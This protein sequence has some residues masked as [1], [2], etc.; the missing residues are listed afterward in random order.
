[1]EKQFHCCNESFR[2]LGLRTAREA[3]KYGAAGS[4]IG[5]V[6]TAAFARKYSRSPHDGEDNG[7][8]YSDEEPEEQDAEIENQYYNS[9]G[10][11]ETDP[12]GA[13]AGFAEVVRME[14]EKSEWGFKALKQTVKL[15]YKLGNY[16]GMMDAYS[17]MLTYI[18]SAV[19][20]N[21]S[22]KC[23]NNIMDFVS[24]SATENFGLLQEFY[25]TTLKALEEPKNE[26]LWFKTN[27][28]LCKIWFHMR[29]YGRMSKILEELHKS[30]QKEG[31]RDDQK[32]GTQLLEVYAI[33]IQLYMET[34][35]NKK[36][37][38][39]YKKALS[40]KSAIPHPNMRGIIHECGG[41]MHMAEGH[42]AEAATDFFEAFK[43]YD[44][45]RNQRHIQCLKY[46]VLVN[47]LMESK[48]TPLDSQEAKPYKNDPE[49][50]AMTNL[51]AAYQQN[52]ALEFERILKTNRS[53]IMDDPFI[54]NYI[55]DLLKNVRSE[56][57]LK[58]KMVSNVTP[59][60]TM[61]GPSLQESLLDE[62][63]THHI[64][65]LL[66]IY[67]NQDTTP[68]YISV[69]EYFEAF[70]RLTLRELP[71]FDDWMHINA[72][73]VD[74]ESP[75]RRLK[76]PLSRITYPRAPKGWMVV[77]TDAG[78][79]KEGGRVIS[80]GAFVF[81]DE[82]GSIRHYDTVVLS[83][84]SSVKE[85]EFETIKFAMY[86]GVR[87][88]IRKLSVCT[89]NFQ[90]L[91]TIQGGNPYTEDEF[92]KYRSCASS[93][94]VRFSCPEGFVETWEDLGIA[95]QEREDAY[96]TVQ[97][98]KSDWL[99]DGSE[100]VWASVLIAASVYN[101]W[102]N[103]F[104][105][106]TSAALL[107][108]QREI[109]EQDT[110]YFHVAHISDP[111][112]SAISLH[113]I[114]YHSW[115]KLTLFLQGEHNFN[116]YG[117]WLGKNS[118]IYGEEFETSE[119]YACSSSCFSWIWSGKIICQGRNQECHLL[120]VSLKAL[121]LVLESVSGFSVLYFSQTTLQ[122]DY[123]APLLKQLIDP[124][125]VECCLRSRVI[126]T[127]DLIN[128]P[129]IKKAPKK[130]VAAMLEPIED[131]LAEG[132]G[133]DASEEK[134]QLDLQSLTSKGNRDSSRHGLEGWWNQSCQEGAIRQRQRRCLKLQ[135]RKAE[136]EVL[137]QLPRDSDK[138]M[139]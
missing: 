93:K 53:T 19:P 130:R 90:I 14:S 40:I 73:R 20:R 10:L 51:I 23:I 126:R 100:F 138:S 47:M 60:A 84:V 42:W 118:T 124:L 61:V 56:V 87:I 67:C 69:V 26:R 65:R 45:A 31:G 36:L 6:S 43:N 125:R 34:K 137:G 32:K 85:A 103:G 66:P 101:I 108:G 111:A 35:N 114:T 120:T 80:V 115:N 9:K 99:V 96:L 37:K 72:V 123:L 132:N 129:G 94:P 17:V 49:V 82:L 63:Y 8:E 134:P 30:C 109:L 116:R 22:E 71:E 68:N 70:S 1:M 76:D 5:A 4:V 29:E 83:W 39:L 15:Y 104:I 11:F 139:R 12:E 55:E 117:E 102:E 52:E 21:Y 38:E 57:L 50:L 92:D 95:F 97:L 28:K 135:I 59:L 3:A 107:H 13:L 46:L 25:Q 24:G 113:I 79:V 54:R 136:D 64:D 16:K 89:D 91:K 78:F 7:F 77:Q 86:E 41:K 33:E 62:F 58:L 44:D 74:T 18:K 27:L 106:C 112:F 48:V 75:T 122:V 119:G 98:G 110:Y 131:G 88:G 81:F 121:A 133:D 128:L 2:M 105:S 127:A